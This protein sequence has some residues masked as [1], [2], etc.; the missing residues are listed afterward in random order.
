[1]A[2]LAFRHDEAGTLEPEILLV[3]PDAPSRAALRDIIAPLARIQ[4]V[5][6]GEEALRVATSRELAAILIDVTL[7]DLDAFETVTKL[8]ATQLAR[9]VPV[10][11]LSHVEPDW[12]TQ[13]QSY[14]LGALGFLTKPVDAHILRAKLEVLLTLFS[15]GIEL[16]QRDQMIAK[17]HA[18]IHEA[19]AA[20]ESVTAASRTKD[21]YLGM[22]G[23]D[24]R[25]PLAAILM[26]S[27]M[28][29]M[30]GS[31]GGDDRESVYRI[32]RNAERMA[33][34]IRDILDYVRGQ[35]TG[36]IPISPRLTH[37]GDIC[38][39]M[40]EEM[41]LLHAHRPIRLETAGE[42]R[43][44]WD[45][46]RIEQVLSNLLTNALNHGTG[47]ITLDVQGGLAEVVLRVHNTGDAIREDQLDCLFEPFR[48]GT[49]SPLGLGLG[50]YIV[51]E[52]VRAHGGTVQVEST[53]EA[54][55]TFTTR[56]PRP[57]ASL[58]VPT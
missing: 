16:R 7:P 33:A 23:H 29:L 4:E 17:Q 28:M 44:Y 52:I 3:D 10:L 26:S 14:Q 9:N 55:T 1:M 39:A 51:R 47:P 27:R 19:Q 45:R 11:F 36:G 8:R 31:M 56:W 40:I 41:S 37:M 38:V 21:V 18:A 25:N 50:L 24:L 43:G 48:R 57:R 42:L 6:T 2:H 34:L 20:L 13:R 15:R 32:A 22:L 58:K 30:R 5:T 35:A 46:D 12:L 54:G 53:A 49:N